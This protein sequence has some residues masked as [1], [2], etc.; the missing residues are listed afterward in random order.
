M[1]LNGVRMVH[2]HVHCGPCYH[3]PCHFVLWS[4]I[5]FTD[6]FK[7]YFLLVSNMF[8]VVV[9]SRTFVFCDYSIVLLLRT[10]HWKLTGIRL[11]MLSSN[12]IF[13]HVEKMAACPEFFSLHLILFVHCLGSLAGIIFWGFFVS[14][15][16]GTPMAPWRR[17]QTKPG[18]RCMIA[19]WKWIM[20][21]LVTSNSLW[22]AVPSK[23]R[24]EH[25]YPSSHHY[26]SVWW[27]TFWVLRNTAQKE[28][29]MSSRQYR[30]VMLC[31]CMNLPPLFEIPDGRFGGTR[32]KQRKF[33]MLSEW[34]STMCCLPKP[35]GFIQRHLEAWMRLGGYRI[36]GR[37]GL[38]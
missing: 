38:V 27:P 20:R 2:E 19:S 25:T 14:S 36:P 37:P 34:L 9:V 11:M 15:F 8:I 16:Q 4:Y 29:A 24:P 31:G 18:T 33:Q 6:A 10:N 30:D 5:M 22:Q 32:R 3:S 26:T 1:V 7:R 35:E 17:C 23:P 21:C 13:C 12:G 28:I